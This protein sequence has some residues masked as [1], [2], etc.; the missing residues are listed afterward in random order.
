VAQQIKYPFSHL[1]DVNMPYRDEIA[2]ALLRV[3]DSGRYIGGPELTEFENTLAAAM[4]APYAIGVTNGLDALRLIFRA[5]L[6]LGR[7][8]PGDEVIVPANTYVASILAV[9]DNGLTPVFVEPDA[10]TLN[11]DTAR[12]EAAVTPRTRAILPVHLYG[13]VCWD[14]TIADVARRHNLIV[15]EDNAQAIGVEADCD[16]LFTSRNTGALGHA[17][18]FSFYPTKNIGALGDGGA[19]VTHDA[20]LAAAIRAIRNYGSDRQYHN[21]Y[22][23]LNCRLDPMKAAVLTIKLK[24][25]HEENQLRRERAAIYNTEIVN[26]AVTKPQWLPD[27]RHVWHQYIVRVDNRDTFRKYLLDNGVETAVHYATPPHRQPCYSEYAGLH[28]PVTDEI[29]RTVVSLPITRTTSLDD[30]H[31]IAAIINAAPRG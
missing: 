17:G 29:A 23:G 10:V 21:I 19:V 5:Y 31:A 3:L 18:A 27:N 30:A 20:E 25:L 1:A 22:K 12:I 26:P 11:L 13:R 7:L 16:G 24:H 2:A 4:H 14:K 6:E 28:L 8:H 15:V 9:T